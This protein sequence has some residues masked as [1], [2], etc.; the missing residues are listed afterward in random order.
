MLCV[1]KAQGK[2]GLR[3][4][5]T[6][7]RVCRTYLTACRGTSGRTADGDFALPEGGGRGGSV[8]L[9]VDTSLQDLH[10]VT[11]TTVTNCS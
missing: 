11:C 2:G 9:E 1:P 4:I 3:T 10:H 7:H 8:V 5:R 6:R